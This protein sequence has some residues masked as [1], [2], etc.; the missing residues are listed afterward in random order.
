MCFGKCFG[1]FLNSYFSEKILLEQK[2]IKNQDTT[3]ASM[4]DGA[5]QKFGEKTEITR[6]VRFAI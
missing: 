4:L 1:P 6:F 2:F 5:V 3:I